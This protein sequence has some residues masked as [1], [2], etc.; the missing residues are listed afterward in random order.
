MALGGEINADLA[1]T[2]SKIGIV[3]CLIAATAIANN[4][5][6]VNANTKHFSRIVYA[7]YGLALEN[8]REA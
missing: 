3:D 7:G 1:A 5:I 2:G 4:L 8:W 6:L